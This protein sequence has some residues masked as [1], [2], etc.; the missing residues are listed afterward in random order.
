MSVNAETDAPLFTRAGYA[1]LLGDA[2]EA[3]YCFL[4]FD[5]PARLA[6]DSVC[7]LRHDVDADLGAALDLAQIEADLGVRSTYFVMLRSP[8]YNV[9]GRA[10]IAMVREILSLGHWLGL[11]FDVSFRPGDQRKAEEWV[12]FE[13]RVLA[14][15]FNTEVNVVSYHQPGKSEQPLPVGFEGMVLASS[16]LDLP[17][18]FYLSDSNKAE[19][20]SRLPQIFRNATE[21]RFQ[22]LVHPIW[23]VTDDPDAT[24]EQLWTDAILRNLGRL[25]DQLLTGEGAFGRPRRVSIEPQ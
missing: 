15:T 22:L 8:L 21:P 19:R 11:H 12:Q 10:S 17:G 24:T 20:A 25:Q 14:E 7:L 18:F 2:L 13:R 5:D 16:E 3:G 23:W 4:A 6:E 9:L 1:R